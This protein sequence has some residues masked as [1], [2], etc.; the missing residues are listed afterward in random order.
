L[1]FF[2][3]PL[4]TPALRVITLIVAY[5]KSDALL[6]TCP[7]F[8]LC[9]MKD[10]RVTADKTSE[11]TL[12][13]RE[14]VLK[15]LTKA[16]G[17]LTDLEILNIHKV[18]ENDTDTTPHLA[19]RLFHFEPLETLLRFEYKRQRRGQPQAGKLHRRRA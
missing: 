15:I 16:F 4:Y 19:L 2:E 8:L 11:G 13:E 17:A 12:A 18:N 14:G 9:G 6:C 7:F 10:E 1:K 3:S 5:V